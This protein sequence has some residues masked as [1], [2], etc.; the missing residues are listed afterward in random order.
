MGSKQRILKYLQIKGI[1]KRDFARDT[2]LS[3]T[4]LNSGNNLG[5]DKLEK[6]FSAYP[7]INLYWV[8]TGTGD[9]ILTESQ[10][11]VFKIESSD[12]SETELDKYF[13]MNFI[14][15][16]SKDEKSREILTLFIKTIFNQEY[17]IKIAEQLMD[18]DLAKNLI[19][20]LT[21]SLEERNVKEN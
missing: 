1:G 6:I 16:I 9:M 13:Q 19:N 18:E 21:K 17:A 12:L 2:G 8:I 7:D 5:T 4:I 11:E 3:H 14:K 10:S 20:S 15:A